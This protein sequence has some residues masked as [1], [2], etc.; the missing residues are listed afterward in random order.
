M[1]ASTVERCVN[2]GAFPRIRDLKLRSKILGLV[3]VLLAIVAINAV[4]TLWKLDRIGGEIAD[5]AELDNLRGAAA[6]L[7]RSAAELRRVR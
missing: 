4:I 7:R 1:S 2:R 5:V 3:A 6:R